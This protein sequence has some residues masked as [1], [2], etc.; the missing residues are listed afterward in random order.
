[1]GR[2]SVIT[3]SDYRTDSSEAAAG[4]RSRTFALYGFNLGFCAADFSLRYQGD[5]RRCSELGDTRR[6]GLRLQRSSGDRD[7]QGSGKKDVRLHGVLP[8]CGP[9]A[10]YGIVLV[11]ARP[12]F[13]L[14]SRGAAAARRPRSNGGAAISRTAPKIS[15][16]FLI[17]QPW[18]GEWQ[19]SAARSPP[20]H[21]VDRCVLGGE[22]KSA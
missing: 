7:A 2:D 19:L 6:G 17:S 22:I 11:A 16:A 21:M 9:T 13:R 8:Q 20:R 10:S 1:M 14:L 3:A 5:F 18:R 12:C 4:T 15:A